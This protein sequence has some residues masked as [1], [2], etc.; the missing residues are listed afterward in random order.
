[1]CS[2]A[3]G[4]RQAHSPCRSQDIGKGVTW[5]KKTQAHEGGNIQHRGE[6]TRPLEWY[7]QRSAGICSCVIFYG[8]LFQRHTEASDEPLFPTRGCEKD[9][10][11]PAQLMQ[12]LVSRSSFNSSGQACGHN[13]P[14]RN[15]LLKQPWGFWGSHQNVGSKSHRTLCSAVPRSAFLPTSSLGIW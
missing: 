10:E 2:W 14:R 5:G 9:K 13:C 15:V 4:S 1:M 11:E 12:S 8:D 7:L 3:L 6:Q